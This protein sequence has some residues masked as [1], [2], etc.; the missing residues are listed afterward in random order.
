MGLVGKIKDDLVLIS[1]QE[2]ELIRELLNDFNYIEQPF[3]EFLF[4]DQQPKV[5]I[6]VSN[7]SS[8][9]KDVLLESLVNKKERTYFLVLQKKSQT[10]EDKEIEYKENIVSFDFD[11]IFTNE[12]KT[13]LK[14]VLTDLISQQRFKF[15]SREIILYM[16]ENSEN[17]KIIKKELELL[18]VK[19]IIN[20]NTYEELENC[21]LR[22]PAMLYIGEENLDKLSEIKKIYEGSVMIV[23]QR[24]IVEELNLKLNEAWIV[25][26][27]PI[28]YFKENI[29]EST[30]K[31]FEALNKKETE[32]FL[33][34]NIYSKR[35]NNSIYVILG[36]TCAGKSTL[37][38]GITT[39][40]KGIKKVI[41]YT[42]RKKRPNEIDKK[43]KVFLSE[44]EFKRR[45]KIEGLFIHSYSS[46][47][48]NYKYGISKSMLLDLNKGYDVILQ[49]ISL[50]PIKEISIYISIL[51][52]IVY[53]SFSID[54][55]PSI[56]S[57]KNSRV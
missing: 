30:K 2:S 12:G 24:K 53:T 35:F 31:C 37:I 33:K 9:D 18:G 36:P 48:Y 4:P 57:I 17:F 23:A 5:A 1:S 21:L 10:A 6:Y 41:E 52:I 13:K 38:E 20:C 11:Y 43:E 27:E 32:M 22:E 16:K 51:L 15:P 25:S 19:Q 55:V 56:F 40:L 7:S 26:T 54:I 28:D 47:G 8:L 42:T 14:T 45:E 3:S 34:S 49:L 29:R 50:K 39:D 46:E 44:E